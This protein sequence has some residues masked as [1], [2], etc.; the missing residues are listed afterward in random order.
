MDIID[1][2]ET[3]LMDLLQ[4]PFKILDRGL[5]QVIRINKCQINS[6]YPMKKWRKRSADISDDQVY[7]ALSS[8]FKS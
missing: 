7:V 1:Y 2:Q 8:K 3:F 5:I 4:N 6:S